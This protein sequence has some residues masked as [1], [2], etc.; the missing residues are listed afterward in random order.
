MNAAR[1]VILKFINM[2]SNATVDSR[3]L[4]EIIFICRTFSYTPIKLNLVLKASLETL[5][6]TKCKIPRDECSKYPKMNLSKNG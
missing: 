6:S 4:V 2:G 3:I 1:G 5:K